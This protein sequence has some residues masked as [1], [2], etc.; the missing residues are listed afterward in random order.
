MDKA[1]EY[2]VAASAI[3]ATRGELN[4]STSLDDDGVDLCFTGVTTHRRLRCR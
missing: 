1:A 2:L 3:L 4:V